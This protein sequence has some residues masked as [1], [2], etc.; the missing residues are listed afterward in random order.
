MPAARPTGSEPVFASPP[1]LCYVNRRTLRRIR[2]HRRTT[3]HGVRVGRNPRLAIGDQHRLQ[4]T[5]FYGR[6]RRLSH[7]HRD[8]RRNSRSRAGAR[9]PRPG[10]QAALRERRLAAAADRENGDLANLV[11]C[12]DL[13]FHSCAHAETAMREVGRERERAAVW[14]ERTLTP[15]GSRR[16]DRRA[17]P[18]D[19]RIAAAVA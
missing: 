8:V 2:G 16:R 4:L 17:R 12:R 13:D 9:D 11:G 18:S 6:R 14:C 3:A 7:A 5:V 15:T 1:P 19:L 10:G